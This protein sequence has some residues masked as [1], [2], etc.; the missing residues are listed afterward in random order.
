MKS[1]VYKALIV[2]SFVLPSILPAS[3]SRGLLRELTPF[4]IDG[5]NSFLV[6][7]IFGAAPFVLP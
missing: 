3:C 1:R 6:D 4:L 5:S 7:F 2:G